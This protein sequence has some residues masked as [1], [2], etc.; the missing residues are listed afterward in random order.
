MRHAAAL[1]L[2]LALAGAAPAQEVKFGDD[3][4]EYPRDNE[5]DD[6]RFHGT[7]MAA[8]LSW[9]AVGRDATDCR[10]L[11]EAGRVA[12]WDIDAARAATVCE[13][14]K[15]GDDSSE[16]AGDGTCDD[17]R[18]EGPG[19]AD[20]LYPDDSGRDASDCRRL[21]EFGLVFRRDY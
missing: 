10:S 4:G 12:P 18:F 3:S 13:A 14:V 1:I 11:M 5:C 9:E 19:A 21:C 20:L 2:T 17:P 15:W 8:V 7:A 16:Y 6:R